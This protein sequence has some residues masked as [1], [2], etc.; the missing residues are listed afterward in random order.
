[1]KLSVIYRSLFP[2]A[3]SYSRRATA[4]VATINQT[5]SRV[6]LVALI[7]LLPSV[8]ALLP[9]DDPDIWWHLR[10]GE[11]IIRAGWVPSTDPFSTFG[12]GKPWVAYSWLF[13]IGLYAI[14]SAFGLGGIV[15]LT[16]VLGLLIA[17]VLHRLVRRSKLSFRNE[18]L[19]TAMALASM[20]SLMSPRPWLFSILFFTLE[21][22][23]L[24]EYRRSGN[25]RP[26]YWL[27]LIFC[28]W[29][30]IHVQFVYGLVLL[31]FALL[32]PLLVQWFFSAPRAGANLPAPAPGALLVAALSIIATLANPYHLFVYRPVIEYATQ[33]EV[34]QNIAELH[35]LF[36]RNPIDWIFLTLTLA[37]AFALGWRKEHGLFPYVLLAMG[38]LLSFRARRDIWVGAMA[39]VAILSDRR[40]TQAGADYFELSR[41]KILSV[42]VIVCITLLFSARVRKIS[43]PDLQAHVKEKFPVD[44]AAFVRKHNLTGPLY[45]HFDWGGF[46]IW[47]LPAL[48]VSMDGRT[49]IQD[50]KR[51]E[52]N[53]AVWSGYPQ[54]ESDPELGNAKLIIAEIGRPLTALLHHDRRFE[55][56]YED[57]I[58]LVF[59]AKSK[60]EP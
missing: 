11:W 45:N 57:R 3:V 7:Y 47:S 29:A 50:E 20:K 26:L 9:I 23:L 35:P 44:A 54:W 51:I 1:M 24:L 18:I 13:E 5:V 37:A 52:T 38:V 2:I 17:L 22:S 31:I 14:H 46:L 32:E 56:V 60:R 10:T 12:Y 34:F 27:P 15:F 33:T 43:E 59:V 39:A 42:V 49:N 36:F 28:F 21:L 40:V 4:G 55:V 6:L 19:V 25:L 30:N 58:A 16:V 41:T 53:L 48:K 8:Q